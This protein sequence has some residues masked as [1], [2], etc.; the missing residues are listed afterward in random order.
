[1]VLHGSAKRFVL[2]SVDVHKLIKE[3]APALR[4]TLSELGLQDHDWVVKTSTET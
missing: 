3:E 2:C 4:G 1:M